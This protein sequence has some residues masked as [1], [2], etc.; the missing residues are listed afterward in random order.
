M[1]SRAA[2]EQ[3]ISQAIKNGWK[4]PHSYRVY[5]EVTEFSYGAQSAI[6]DNEQLLEQLEEMGK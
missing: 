5:E 1:S 6:W 4:K 2:L 3:A